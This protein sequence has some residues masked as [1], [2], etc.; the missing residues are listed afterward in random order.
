MD[1]LTPVTL[2]ARLRRVLLFSRKSNPSLS[3]YSRYNFLTQLLEV[4]FVLAVPGSDE[5][6]VE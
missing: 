4:R 5:W 6:G 2:S 3:R 1:G